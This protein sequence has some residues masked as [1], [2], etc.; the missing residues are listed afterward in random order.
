[1]CVCVRLCDCLCVS[2]FISFLPSRLNFFCFFLW[3]YLKWIYSCFDIRL[4]SYFSLPNWYNVR[5]YWLSASYFW[6]LARTRQQIRRSE[7][8]AINKRRILFRSQRIR[9]RGRL[10]SDNNTH[11]RTHTDTYRYTHTHRHQTQTHAQTQLT[12]PLATHAHICWSSMTSNNEASFK[13][14][15]LSSNPNGREREQ[16]LVRERKRERERGMNERRAA[17]GLLS[18][19]AEM[20]QKC[21]CVPERVLAWRQRCGQAEMGLRLLQGFGSAACGVW[22]A[23]CGASATVDCH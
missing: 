20:W 11:P 16:A 2:V 4:A 12:H 1:M 21:V 22:H 19:L 17:G 5:F 18:S 10:S 3:L 9:S 14:E 15:L 7:G 6:G 13:R 8:A 23:A